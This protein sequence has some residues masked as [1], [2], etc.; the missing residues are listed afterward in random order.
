[1]PQYPSLLSLLAFLLWN[2]VSAA[3][4][5]VELDRELLARWKLAGDVRD[6]SGNKH[7]ARNHG[8]DLR[9]KA[10][11]FDGRTAFLEVPASAKLRLGKG[12]F[13]LTGWV[14]TDGEVDIEAGDLLSCYDP[15]RRRG[16]HL[17]VKTA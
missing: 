9:T 2:P 15:A 6:H 11:G 17:S 3:A 1:M 7:H 10:T 12:D 4:E 13:S 5:K 16:F 8:A 14:H